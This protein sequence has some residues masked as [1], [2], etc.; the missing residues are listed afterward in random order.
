MYNADEVDIARSFGDGDCVDKNIVADEPRK[1]HEKDDALSCDNAMSALDL[2]KD[3]K[4]EDSGNRDSVT[5]N[6]RPP[7]TFCHVP[8]MIN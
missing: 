1:E 6:P 4:S 3:L 8:P 5:R 7:N 2:P